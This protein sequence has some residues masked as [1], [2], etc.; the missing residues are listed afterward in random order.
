M[1]KERK[2]SVGRLLFLISLILLV[3]LVPFLL[4]HAP[5]EAFIAGLQQRSFSPAAVALVVVGLLGS[6]ILLPIPSSLVSTWAGGHLPVWGACLA[7]WTGMNLGAALGFALARRWGA[8]VA[9]RFVAP[10]DLLRM[11]KFGERQAVWILV[12]TR[13]LPILAEAAVVWLGT[14]RVSW[15]QFWPPILLSNLGIALAYS[16]LGNWAADQEWLVVAMSVSV[17]FPLLLTAWARRYLLRKE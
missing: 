14:H 6:D 13:A 5:I 9:Q 2:I 15:R 4:W 12:V 3:P 1:S 7:S 17:A 16:C 8:V 10:S 11:E